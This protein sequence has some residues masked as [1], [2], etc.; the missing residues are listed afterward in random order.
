MAWGR[1][2]SVLI[3]LCPRAPSWFVMPLLNT[4][5]CPK[6]STSDFEHQHDKLKLAE[7]VLA[8]YYAN[9]TLDIEDCPEH[10]WV[11]CCCCAGCISTDAFRSSIPGIIW[12]HWWSVTFY[13]C[14]NAVELHVKFVV[15]FMA[16][17][18]CV[19]K[20]S[21]KYTI[22]SAVICH[23]KPILVICVTAVYVTKLV[24]LF[25]VLFVFVYEHDYWLISLKLD[26]TLGA[27]EGRI[28]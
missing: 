9:A 14:S 2:S 18:K 6:V 25:L 8:Y 15:G 17:V 24:R 22:L 5:L 12:H 4:I 13:H 28:N 3:G 1:G 21:L 23:Y 10:Y 7:T 11:W 16:S 20:T 26:V 19:L 27:P